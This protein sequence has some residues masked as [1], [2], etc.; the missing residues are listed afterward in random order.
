MIT[1]T[2][3]RVM[4]IAGAVLLFALTLFMPAE[5]LAGGQQL[6]SITRNLGENISTVPRLIALGAYVIGAFFAVR[7]LFA[8]KGFIESPDD[9]PITKVLGFAAVSALLIM[10]PF[11]I[12]VMTDVLTA[13]GNS[14][15]MKSSGQQFD[16][17]T[18]L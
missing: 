1:N 13:K 12:E 14:A 7:A 4:L 16:V 9:N 3:T 10:L 5:A 18:G 15:Q 11:V 17:Q 6:K 8:L 2:T